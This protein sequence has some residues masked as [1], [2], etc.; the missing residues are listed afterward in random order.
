MIVTDLTRMYQGRVCIAGYDENQPCIRP[1][2]PPPGIAE[3]AL[4]R[5]H[6]PLVYPFAL[7]ELELTRPASKP[8]HTEDYY[9]NPESI[10]HLQAVQERRAVLQRPLFQNVQAIFEQPVQRRPGYYVL[11][12]Q[13]ARSLGTIKPAG[14]HEVRYAMDDHG[15]WDYRLGF[16]DAKDAYYRRSPT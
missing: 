4:I 13:G 10:V 14:I 15:A 3:S 5:D 12:C 1:I 8:P 16:Y 2:L 7:I 6:K 9:F 11:E